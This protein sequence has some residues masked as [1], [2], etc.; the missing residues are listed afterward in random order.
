MTTR[1]TLSI[2]IGILRYTNIY[3]GRCTH[4]SIFLWVIFPVALFAAA[5]EIINKIINDVSSGDQNFRNPCLMVAIMFTGKALYSRIVPSSCE[6]DSETESEQPNISDSNKN[7]SENHFKDKIINLIWVVLNLLAYYALMT[8]YIYIPASMLWMMLMAECSILRFYIIITKYGI[9]D[10]KV[11]SYYLEGIGLSLWGWTL[12]GWIVYATN[13][14]DFEDIIL[15]LF[16]AGSYL[17]LKSC[18]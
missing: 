6:Q 16:W 14:I 13:D 7:S 10:T 8:A 1:A 3:I 2:S 17:T 9:F 15:S 4:W 11:I 18:K 5:E 12:L